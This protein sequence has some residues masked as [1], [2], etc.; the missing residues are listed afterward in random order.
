M[1]LLPLSAFAAIT[2]SRACLKNHSRTPHFAGDFA[3]SLFKHTLIIAQNFQIAGLC[4]HAPQCILYRAVPQVSLE[5]H[6]ETVFPGFSRNRPGLDLGHIQTIID[7][8]GKYIVKSSACM[9]CLEAYTNPGAVVLINRFLCQNNKSGHIAVIF[10]DILC[11]NLQIINL[12]GSPA[13]N[14]GVSLIPICADLFWP[15]RRCW[16]RLWFSN[17]Y[18]LPDIPYTGRAPRGWEYT[19]AISESSASCRP[20]STCSTFR[21]CSPTINRLYSVKRS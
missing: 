15:L 21:I 2:G 14:C 1:K 3:E 7:H 18:A 5:V 6:E 11:Q 20:S 10:A 8:M 16:L 17:L 13:G 12:S 4:F 19:P 9:T